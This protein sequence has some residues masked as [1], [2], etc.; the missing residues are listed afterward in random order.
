MRYVWAGTPGMFRV[1]I[2]HVEHRADGFGAQGTQIAVE[3]EAY[4]LHYEVDEQR[5]F[6][7]IVGGKSLSVGLEDADF[8]D[9]GSSPLFNS[10]PVIRHGLHRGGEPRDFVMTWV[11]VPDL[12]VSR[13]EQRYDPLGGEGLVRFSTGSFKAD[14][15]FD[16]DGFVL[17]YP[18]LAERVYP[19]D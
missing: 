3:D 6:V 8:F 4:E 11:S 1:E 12:A 2:A 5:L 19:D 9:L 14:I 7:E 16:S 10:F 15:E 13:S 17:A 18:E